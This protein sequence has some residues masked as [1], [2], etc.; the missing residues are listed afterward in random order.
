M[1]DTQSQ[2]V[3][4]EYARTKLKRPDAIL[5]AYW[6]GAIG[7]TLMIHIR[8]WKLNSAT[9]R[10]GPVTEVA[11]YCPIH[12]YCFLTSDYPNGCPECTKE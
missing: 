5:T 11:Q 2:A 6:I 3:T 10:F 9:G 12:R 8:Y 1:I 7:D 4:I